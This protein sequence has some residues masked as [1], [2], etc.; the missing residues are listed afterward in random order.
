MC[1]EWGE[2]LPLCALLPLCTWYTLGGGGGG[3]VLILGRGLNRI[4]DF[5]DGIHC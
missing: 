4:G 1:G 2:G 3:G 5:S